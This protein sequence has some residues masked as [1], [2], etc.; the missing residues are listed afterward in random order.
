AEGRCSGR[1]HAR[2]N[3]SFVAR[4]ERSDIRGVPGLA[5][6]DPGYGSTRATARSGLRCADQ[7]LG[8][9]FANRYS[10]MVVDRRGKNGAPMP[11]H[12]VIVVGAGN[13][14]FCAALAAQERGAKVL[15]IEAAP[16]E[17]SGGNSRFTAG[18][19]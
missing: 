15:M 11:D 1:L 4:M 3:P 19:I 8:F 5:A 12:D 2:T 13:A 16:E 7:R 10:L 14:A 18:S 17:E 6:L 9:R